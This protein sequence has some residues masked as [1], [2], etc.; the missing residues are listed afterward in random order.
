MIK[1]I[2]GTAPVDIRTNYKNI[3]YWIAEKEDFYQG[4]NVCC[5]GQ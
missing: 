3:E 1:Y 5:I 4:G 2:Q